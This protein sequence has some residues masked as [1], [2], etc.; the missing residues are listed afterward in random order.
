MTTIKQLNNDLI[1]M[2]RQGHIKKAGNK[3]NAAG[4]SEQRF[5]LSGAVNTFT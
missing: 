5:C 1:T 4:N 3:Y 2:E